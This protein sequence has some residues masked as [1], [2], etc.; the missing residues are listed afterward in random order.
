MTGFQDRGLMDGIF[1]LM[2]SIED[3]DEWDNSLLQISIFS[4][5]NIFLVM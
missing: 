1:Y 4:G 3:R 5:T 2:V